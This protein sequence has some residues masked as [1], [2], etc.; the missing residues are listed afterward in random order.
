[1]PRPRKSNTFMVFAALALALAVIG[2]VPA[3]AQTDVTTSRI[4]GQ[5]KDAEGGVLPGVSVEARN[6]ETGLVMRA[7]TDGEGSFKVLNLPI[8]TYAVSAELQG[9]AKAS[10]DVR[11]T[12]GSA[13]T[14]DFTMQLASVAEQITVTA[15]V[16]LVEVTNT[17]AN[18]TILTEQ[19]NS[20]PLNGRNFSDLVYLTPETNNRNERNYISISGQRGINTNVM[21]DGVDNNNA[22]FG[23]TTGDAEGRAP[24]S[25][26]KESIKEFTVITN[27]ASAEFGRSGGG[28]V[29]VITKSGTNDFH[30]GAFY[31]YQPESMVADFPKGYAPP[32]DFEKEQYGANLGGAIVKDRLFFFGSYDEQKQSKSVPISSS[33]LDANVFTKWPVLSSP[34]QYTQT[35][36]GRVV[37]GRFDWLLGNGH[38]IMARANYADYD[39]VNGTSDSSTRT[40]SFNGLEAMFSRSYV[41]NYS[42]VFGENLIN[43]LNVQYLTEDTPRADKS[44]GLPEIQITSGS[45]RY[46]EVGFLPIVSTNTRT[47]FS[48]SLSYV[49]GD[50]VLK[51]GFD[52]NDT[53][54]DQ[55]FKGNWRG[56]FIFS[57]KND[58]IAGRWSEYRQFGGL[59]GLT[60][61]EAGRSAFAQKETALFIQDQWYVS[62]TLTVSAGLRWEKLDN[63]DIDILNINDQNADGS[64]NLTGEIPDTDDQWS[65]RLGVT[66]APNQKTAVRF[67]AGRF[68]SRT[69][70]LLWAQANTAN[71]YRATQY[72]M[73]A[74]ASGPTDPLASYVGW[75][76]GSSAYPAWVPEG[77]ARIPFSGLGAVA[78]PGVFT[79]A[80]DYTNAHTDRFTLEWQQEVMAN[81][82][83]TLGATY[84]KA[85]DLEYITDANLQYLCTDGTSSPNCTP[86]TGANG[87]P[88]YSSVKPYPYYG[89][90]SV[91]SSGAES[92]YMGFT[93]MIQRRFAERFSGFLSAT[94]SK[95][96]DHDSNE[97]N[98]AGL[99]LEDKNDL[100]NNWGYSNRDQEWKIAANGTWN[101]FWGIDLSGLFK[102]AT[103]T[104][105]TAYTNSDFNADGDRFTDRPT[106]DG[107]HLDRNSFRNDDFWTLDL[108]LAKK[109]KLGPGDISLIAECF[110]VTD[111][112][113]FYVS[114]T[115]WGTGQTPS[116]SFGAET[117]GGTPRTYQFALRYD[118]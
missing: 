58:L 1:M 89:R 4:S 57:S 108:R 77:V 6:T 68:W 51:G 18:T 117:Y 37:F 9:F 105:Y 43:D 36:D 78:K 91:V 83:V 31:Y 116:S 94:Y 24:L 45:L 114:N 64:F 11:L 111:E 13:P 14:V 27:G 47:Q 79:V 87:M 54:I 41:G 50:H 98:Y 74:G 103:G 104:P 23:G 85:A 67:S 62:P 66:W 32:Q 21:I 118:F 17:T 52:Y 81:T 44:L 97:R 63:P 95:D 90:I 19:I 96:K 110:N 40:E 71:G 10:R 60:A 29:N 82:S 49:V 55:V 56:V 99:N 107:V 102:Y 46:G 80:E 112:Q 53:D 33:V 5:V 88:K 73:T 7:V 93:A 70:G 106:I 16:P 59:N 84:A 76:S 92:E 115:T 2:A 100:E 20:L 48:D 39:G 28:F 86:Q 72:I 25:V 109:I 35:K 69:P 8:G 75:G 26:S 12:L 65:P 101:A 30:G 22:F 61:D 34:D 15:Q 3:L 113:Y 42:A 38:R